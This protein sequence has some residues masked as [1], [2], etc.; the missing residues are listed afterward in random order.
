MSFTFQFDNSDEIRDSIPSAPPE[1]RSRLYS[2]VANSAITLFKFVDNYGINAVFV[3]APATIHPL[4]LEGLP[5]HYLRGPVATCRLPSRSLGI[6]AML[7]NVP[8]ATLNYDRTSLH[9]GLLNVFIATSSAVDLSYAVTD[10]TAA[11]TLMFIGLT[12]AAFVNLVISLLLSLEI[13]DMAA[14]SAAT[15]DP[16]TLCAATCKELET[17]CALFMRFIVASLWMP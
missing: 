11:Q 14:T 1:L 15:K 9:G 16:L 13:L 2:S 5:L 10:F 3:V 6:N 17:S 12:M 7:A 4:Q 8:A